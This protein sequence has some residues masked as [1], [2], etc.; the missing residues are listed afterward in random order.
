M[1]SGVTELAETVSPGYRSVSCNAFQ[2]QWR[3]N[4]KNEIFFP[5]PWS[6]LWQ[7][8]SFRH[9]FR[10]CSCANIVIQPTCWYFSSPPPKRQ[11]QPVP[12][13]FLFIFTYKSQLTYTR[14]IFLSLG[15]SRSTFL[16]Y[17]S[18]LNHSFWHCIPALTS[19]MSPGSSAAVLG[20][21]CCSSLWMMF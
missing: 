3:Y 17:H 8:H 13:F 16:H 14:W 11:P 19:Q 7:L 20:L 1:G 5:P 10:I 4:F 21:F 15:C 18:S 12:P 9:L 6:L 2:N